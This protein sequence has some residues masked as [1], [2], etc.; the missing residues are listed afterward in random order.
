M[1]HPGSSLLNIFRLSY[2][3]SNRRDLFRGHTVEAHL[4]RFFGDAQKFVASQTQECQFWE[5][6]ESPSLESLDFVISQ[7]DCMKFLL[8]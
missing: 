2:E 1:V 6:H 8:N 5:I 3:P 4:K 7:S